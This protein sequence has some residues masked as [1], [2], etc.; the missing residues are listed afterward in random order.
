MAASSD[1][2]VLESLRDFQS[3]KELMSYL[4]YR[5]AHADRE[6]SLLQSQAFFFA[7]IVAA[8]LATLVYYLT[9]DVKSAFVLGSVLGGIGV[10]AGLVSIGVMVAVST[11][12]LAPTPWDTATIT[13]WRRG[14]K[15][16]LD[17]AGS[18]EHAD[19]VS[20]DEQVV[21]CHNLDQ[22]AGGIEQI[23]RDRRG[24]VSVLK[25]CTV[26]MLGIV[27]LILTIHHV[28]E[29]G[30]NN[31]QLQALELVEPVEAG[32]QSSEDS[33][34]ADQTREEV[35]RQLEAEEMT[36]AAGDATFGEGLLPESP[37]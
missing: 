21:L 15:K 17:Q 35:E 13:S 4:S 20:D 27:G 28:R 36:P 33:A 7:G 29:W 6:R 26:G 16:S 31:E 5:L 14:H 19:S 34:A 8:S 1:A 3:R 37:N 12:R 30:T 25:W 10:A 23:N 9:H 32:G 2:E 11:P 18:P 22:V 24:C